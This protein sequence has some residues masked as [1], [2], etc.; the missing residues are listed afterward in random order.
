MPQRKPGQPVQPPWSQTAPGGIISSGGGGAGSTAGQGAGVQNA[1]DRGGNLS[2]IL[3]REGVDIGPQPDFWAD[4]NSMVKRLRPMQRQAPPAQMQAQALRAPAMPQREESQPVRV[5][6]PRTGVPYYVKM[7]GTGPQGIPGYVNVP[8][9]TPG[10]VA[11]G[12][13]RG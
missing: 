13:L 9:G 5:G 12:Y 3:S 4:L 6:Q 7:V 10:A 11:G 1:Y 2:S 8:A